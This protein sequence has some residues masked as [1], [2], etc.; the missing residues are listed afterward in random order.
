MGND[1]AILGPFLHEFGASLDHLGQLLA[2]L[3]QSWGYLW[4]SCG[5][6]G[7]TLDI[8]GHVGAMLR[9]SCGFLGLRHQPV[10]Q[11]QKTHASLKCVNRSRSATVER[12]CNFKKQR[13]HWASHSH[14]SLEPLNRSRS[15]LVE[16]T[17]TNPKPYTQHCSSH[18]DTHMHHRNAQ[19]ALDLRLC[20]ENA[21]LENEDVLKL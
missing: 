1:G 12:E 7:F 2:M 17:H 4:G 8:L 11:T 6:F 13:C 16:R 3:G 15:T 18:T 10:H 21:L 14:T 20:S 9:L 5:L 19:N